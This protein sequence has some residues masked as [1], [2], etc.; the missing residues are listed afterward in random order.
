MVGN[1]AASLDEACDWWD[2]E[3]IFVKSIPFMA[4][5]ERELM[6][7][8][9]SSDNQLTLPEAVTARLEGTEYLEVAVE[10]DR[11]VLT[12]VQVVRAAAVRAKLAKMG[13]TEEDVA[14]AVEWARS[15]VAEEEG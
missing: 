11:I 12:P 8:R 7:A 4:K 2:A 9:L 3:V 5:T 14:D 13:I 1:G 10:A 6:L 15:S